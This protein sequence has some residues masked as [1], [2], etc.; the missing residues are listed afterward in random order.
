MQLLP[1][2]MKSNRIIEKIGEKEFYDIVRK[3]TESMSEKVKTVDDDRESY[4]TDYKLIYNDRYRWERINNDIPEEEQLMPLNL[5][6]FIY[7]DSGM[8]PPRFYTTY[9]DEISALE[10]SGL[11]NDAAYILRQFQNFSNA[12]QNKY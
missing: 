7:Y 1:W 9:F 12:I 4:I 6:H 2:D 10:N 3:E 11:S 5:T 8:L